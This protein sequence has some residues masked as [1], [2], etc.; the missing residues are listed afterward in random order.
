MRRGGYRTTQRV[1][2]VPVSLPKADKQPVRRRRRQ[3]LVDCRQNTP[4]FYFHTQTFGCLP[5]GKLGAAPSW[6]RIRCPMAERQAR[7]PSAEA[8][9]ASAASQPVTDG[10]FTL[11][12]RLTFWGSGGTRILRGWQGTM[13][14]TH[15]FGP[16]LRLETGRVLA[17]L[18]MNALT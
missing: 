10:S 2:H 14:G 16:V 4:A 11:C 18:I 3:A 17:Q 5:L 1:I 6:R 12:A 13:V 15:A 7:R 8:E 9:S